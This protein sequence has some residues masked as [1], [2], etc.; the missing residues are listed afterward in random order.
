V[1]FGSLVG[2]GKGLACVVAGGRQDALLRTAQVGS[3]DSF[4][5]WFSVGASFAFWIIVKIGV[6]SGVEVRQDKF[7]VRSYFRKVYVGFDLVERV[8]LRDRLVIVLQDGGVVELSAFSP[9][10]FGD[11][12]G[13]PSYRS[14]LRRLNGALRGSQKRDICEDL[15]SVLNLNLTVILVSFLFF[16][17]VAQVAEIL[18]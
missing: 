5:F 9:S 10:L 18:A 7:V 2:W 17:L 3:S 11:L 15:N 14:P 16:W 6:I 12:T 1:S 13:N 4:R 8:E